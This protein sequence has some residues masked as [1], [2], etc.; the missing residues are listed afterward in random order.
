M[1]KTYGTVLRQLGPRQ[2]E[3]VIST[4]TEDRMHDRVTAIQ[5]RQ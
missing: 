3:A 4:Q 5:H 2:V 1:N